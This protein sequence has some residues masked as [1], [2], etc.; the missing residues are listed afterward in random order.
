MSDFELMF[1][2]LKSF[3]VFIIAGAIVIWLFIRTTKQN[4]RTLTAEERLKSDDTVKY[5]DQKIISKKRGGK[6]LSLISLVISFTG[7]ALLGY[8]WKV[9]GPRAF[10][11]E[12]NSYLIMQ[13]GLVLLVL[14]ILVGLV[15]RLAGPKK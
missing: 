10:N 12:A 14:G 3:S 13:V 6:T 15:N 9:G 11:Y 5:Y 4:I 7:V 2:L 1:V 8:F